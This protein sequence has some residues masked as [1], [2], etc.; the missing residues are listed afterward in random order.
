M[1][2]G[3][4]ISW[5][6]LKG[7]LLEELLFGLLNEMGA[8]QLVW[9]SGGPGGGS[10]DGGRD[11]EATFHRPTP[12][13][14]IESEYWWVEA[15]GRT[16]TVEP[17]AVKSAVINS[18]D[19]KQLDLILVATNSYFSNPTR[20]WVANWSLNHP[21]P[22]IRLWDRNDL[23]KLMQR[24]PLVTARILPEALPDADRI[25]MLTD[26]FHSAGKPFTPKDLEHF[27][28]A[29]ES[30]TEAQ[31]ISALTYSEFANGDISAH[32][33]GT[34]VTE[35]NALQTFLEAIAVLPF[36]IL[37][38][39]AV[40]NERV[41]AV[42]AYLIECAIR[43]LDPRLI[44][45]ILNN[46]LDFTTLPKSMKENQDG[47]IDAVVRPTYRRCKLEILDA[48]SQD[49]ARITREPSVLRK[50]EYGAEFWRR[51]NTDISLPADGPSLSFCDPY[52]PCSVGLELG[53][54]TC[55]LEEDPT[56]TVEEAEELS[57]IINFRRQH[58]DGRYEE[59]TSTYSSPL[60][61][62]FKRHTESIRETFT[63]LKLGNIDDSKN[64]P[65]QFGGPSD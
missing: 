40:L 63:G 30:I 33:W 36:I 24:Y 8:S 59:I 25:R 6:S 65:D 28:A 17:D 19:R 54:R 64:E 27:W 5:P 41:S 10:S 44:S 23:F 38:V 39:A 22:K 1:A 56:F 15:K 53:E 7:I 55:P 26:Q 50:A 34:L 13:G 16:K 51:F 42:S 32:P 57:V 20:D 58:P 61:E 45:V 62:I 52:M 3:D 18:H 29:R 35:D 47:Y 11:L 48:C 37:R 4:D 9:R 49:C 60:Q 12:D 43:L 14:D 46:P 21:R 31:Q 2:T